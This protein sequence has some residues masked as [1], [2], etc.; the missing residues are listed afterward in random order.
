ME[1]G[2][3][4]LPVPSATGLMN[5]GGAKGTAAASSG[6]SATRKSAVAT[7]A[8]RTTRLV[9][10]LCRVRLSTSGSEKV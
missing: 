6:R 2:V 5:Q 1:A 7:P 4:P 9:S 3:I 10:P 8:S